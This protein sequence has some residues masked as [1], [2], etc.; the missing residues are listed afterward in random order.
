MPAGRLNDDDIA[1]M[2]GALDRRAIGLRHDGGWVRGIGKGDSTDMFRHRL[3]L[4][5]SPVEVVRSLRGRPGLVALIGAWCGGGA[6]V[7]CDP[8]EVL[9]ADADPFAAADHGLPAGAVGDDAGTWFGGGWIGYWGYQLGRRLEHLPAPPPRPC[10]QREHWLARYEWVLHQDACGVWWFESLLRPEQAESL[11]ESVRAMVMRG[12]AGTRS[13]EFGEFRMRPTPEEHV[14]VVSSTLDYI[15][16]G[17]IFQANMCVRM[18]AEFRGD[19]LDVFCAGVNALGPQYAAFVDAGDYAVASFSPELFLRCRGR[20]ILASPIKGTVPAH[21]DPTALAASAKDRAENVMIVDLMRNDLGR[22]CVPG[23]VEVPRLA[24]AEARAGVWHLLSDVSGLLRE[25]LTG[26]DL[27]RA[28]FP[29]GSVTGTP[30]VRAM[31]VINELESTGRELYTGAIGYVS[32]LAGLETNVVIRTVEFA[33]RRA[34]LGVGGGIVADSDPQAEL[35][36]CFVKA[37]PVL[38]AIGGHLADEPPALVETGGSSTASRRGG[39]A[40]PALMMDRTDLPDPSAGI[41][42]TVL[43]RDR[44][45][46]MAEAHAQRLCQSAAE[47]LGKR[48]ELEDLVQVIWRESRCASGDSRLRLTITTDT[49]LDVDIRPLTDQDDDAAWRLIPAVVPGGLGRHKWVD[50]SAVAK[51]LAQSSSTSTDPL[52]LDIHGSVLETGRA[53]VFLVLDDG[54]HTPLADGRILPGT[55]RAAVLTLLAERGIPV[56]EHNIGL[57]DLGDATEVFVTNAVRGVV[58]VTSCDHVGSW[59]IGALTAWLR[60]RLDESWQPGRRPRRD[61]DRRATP[62]PAVDARVLLVDNYDS[63]AYNLAQYAEELGARVTVLRND[64]EQA[65]QLADGFLSDEF[66]HLVISPGPGRPEDAG[67]SAELVRALR[68]RAPILGV[69][70]GHQCIA[71]AY[72]ARVVRSRRPVHGKPALVHHDGLGVF[73]SI[74]GPWVAARYH[75]LIVEEL[76]SDLTASAWTADGTLMGLRHRVHPVEGIQAHPES[77]LTH[78]GHTILDSFLHT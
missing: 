11:L 63:F 48:L 57:D 3:R 44:T 41:F 20:S 17:D 43:I 34:W 47:V 77:I 78:H 30:K 45:P 21:H 2:V 72:G 9:P 14:G 23:T 29:P 73:S 68:G 75:S 7:A 52:L 40:P 60:R 1:A 76:P 36:E 38:A 71:Q 62:S 39:S 70:L 56:H 67:V 61:V 13:Y 69:C 35:S 74:D 10:P 37:R 55:A 59:P 32:P 6:V 18:E 26:A 12:H 53:N 51:L 4:R 58:P 24:G 8:V 22:V 5:L 64:A 49:G 31:E 50:R 16:A 19:P 33:G 66:T 28:A 46:V 54:V 65:G 27:L 15:A 25:G 42:T